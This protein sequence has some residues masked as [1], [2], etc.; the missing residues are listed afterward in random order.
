MKYS[1]CSYVPGAEALA[2]E[3]G[4]TAMQNIMR[5]GRNSIHRKLLVVGMAAGLTTALSLGM[6]PMTLGQAE[7]AEQDVATYSTDDS[8]FWFDLSVKGQG[9]TAATAK[10]NKSGDTSVYI[11]P[12]SMGTVDYCSLYVWGFNNKYGNSDAN[13]TLGKDEKAL[14]SS[15][16]KSSIK[17]MAFERGYKKVR[18]EAYQDSKS[19]TIQ[20]VWSPD[21]TKTY[22]VINVG[23]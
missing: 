14:L 17:T 4:N 10:R 19:G 18:I 21:S 6:M 2:R 3:E 5:S 8:E 20:G 9:K 7:A 12:S 13:V 23:M 22:K 11:Y 16:K 15:A 1:S